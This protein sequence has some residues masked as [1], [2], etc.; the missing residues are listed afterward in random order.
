MMLGSEMSA[1]A[2][3]AERGSRPGLCVSDA[4]G[5]LF[6]DALPASHEGLRRDGRGR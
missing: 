3:S 4:R 1:A 5:Q 6:T 2:R